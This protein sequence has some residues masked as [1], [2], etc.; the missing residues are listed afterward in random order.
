[1]AVDISTDEATSRA[2]CEAAGDY[3]GDCTYTELVIEVLEN[4]TATDAQACAAADLL[5]LDNVTDEADSRA[6]CLGQGACTYDAYFAGVVEACDDN[7]FAICAGADISS[8]SV[9]ASR[10]SCLDAG[11]C[12][13]TA[14]VTETCQNLDAQ[15]LAGNRTGT[16]ATQRLVC[17][18]LG[19]AASW[20]EIATEPSDSVDTVVVPATVR[21]CALRA[22]VFTASPAAVR[23]HSMR[24][25]I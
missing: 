9:T 22:G 21:R 20:P 23:C 12:A 4:C 7:S 14:G 19:T 3:P 10:Q 17:T 13:Y 8:D 5:S 18:R 1:M 15:Y 11:D 2:S 24:R 25:C 6:N 16:R